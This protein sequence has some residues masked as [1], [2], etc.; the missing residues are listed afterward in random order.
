MAQ[1]FSPCGGTQE[2]VL[3]VT[4]HSECA[5]R[6]LL[7]FNFHLRRPPHLVDKPLQHSWAVNIMG[8]IAATHDSSVHDL[9]MGDAPI[10]HTTPHK[11]ERA[12]PNNRIKYTYIA[13]TNFN[14][15]H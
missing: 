1:E 8:V 2:H 4:K 6:E 11:G 7:N 3:Y 15:I 13:Y 12:S 5:F 10:A 9:R 14:A